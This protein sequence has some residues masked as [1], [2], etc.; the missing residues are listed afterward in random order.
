MLAIQYETEN[1]VKVVVYTGH[2]MTQT[3]MTVYPI[4]DGKYCFDGK[5]YDGNGIT[6]EMP[7]ARYTYI[8]TL[9]IEM[10]ALIK[11]S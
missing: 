1:T 8:F 3:E 7:I 9:S 4:L 5:E 6:I 11:V 10:W 2:P